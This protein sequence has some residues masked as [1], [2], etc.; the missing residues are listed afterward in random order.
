MRQ[1]ALLSYT[2]LNNQS[3]IN[4]YLKGPRLF[5]QW[6]GQWC[7]VCMCVQVEACEWRVGECI[8]SSNVLFLICRDRLDVGHQLCVCVWRCVDT[9]LGFI[10]TIPFFPSFAKSYWSL[11]LLMGF[12]R[13][14]FG[15]ETQQNKNKHG[16]LQLRSYKRWEL[17]HHCNSLPSS[18]WCVS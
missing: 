2:L 6:K 18:L 4:N 15:K 12:F 10:V 13:P 5:T 1:Q 11:H 3:F 7:R 8:V 9:S 14:P 17:N 16:L